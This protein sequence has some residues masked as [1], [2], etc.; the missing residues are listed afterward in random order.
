[1]QSFITRYATPLTTGL[2]VVSLVSGVALFFHWEGAYFHAMH[3]WLSM[4]LIIPFVAHIWKNWRP[5]KCY[6]KHQPMMIALALSTVAAIAFAYWPAERP[7]GFRGERAR[8]ENSETASVGDVLRANPL[9]NIAP[10]YGASPEEFIAHLEAHGLQVR[11]A[12]ETL[13]ALARDNGMSTREVIHA[14]AS[15]ETD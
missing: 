2:F 4:L 14:F 13:S 5:M 12:D 1:M 11:S 8:V 10:L 7:D 15:L 3:E 6:F 9:T